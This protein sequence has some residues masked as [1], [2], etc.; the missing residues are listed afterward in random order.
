[1]KDF[2]TTENKHGVRVTICCSSCCYKYKEETIRK[3]VCKQKNRDCNGRDCE[4]WRMTRRLSGAHLSEGRIKKKEY[5]MF[6][7][8]IRETEKDK[9][10]LNPKTKSVEEIRSEYEIKYGSIYMEF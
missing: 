6:L 2:L 5:L 1:M 4:N 7:L 3:C 8:K 9:G 10:G